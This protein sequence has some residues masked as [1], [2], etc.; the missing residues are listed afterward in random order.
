M[1]AITA[2]FFSACKPGNEGMGGG[3]DKPQ[4]YAVNYPLAYF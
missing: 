1:I 3:T 4:V 2:V